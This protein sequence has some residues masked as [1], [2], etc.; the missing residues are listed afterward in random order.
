MARNR[1]KEILQGILTSLAVY[2]KWGKPHQLFSQ[3][4]V[5][6]QAQFSP[7]S[8]FVCNHSIS[9]NV[10]EILQRKAAKD[11]GLS[12]ARAACMQRQ[13]GS[14]ITVRQFDEPH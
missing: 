8:K 13:A 4:N 2:T 5:Q 10:E 11:I 12:V 1:N 9:H 3:P 6:Y 14:V 7:T